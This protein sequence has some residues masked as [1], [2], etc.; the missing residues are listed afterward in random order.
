L[1]LLLKVFVN[2]LQNGIY[3][4][5]EDRTVSVK[6][7]LDIFF[8][9]L[10]KECQDTSEGLPMIPIRED[11][12]QEIYVGE[13]DEEG[14]CRWR[15]IVHGDEEGW[16]RWRPIVHGQKETFINLLKDYGIE[17]N[18]AIVEYFSSYY[19]L[20]FD[21]DYKKYTIAIHSVEPRYGYK[22]LRG[23]IGAYTDKKGKITHIAIG[24][25]EIGYTIV[26]E[27]KTGIV[28]L[29]DDD[30]GRMRK[31]ASSLEE[32]VRGWKPDV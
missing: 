22:N 21:V 8:E 11:I 30:K 13:P 5:E 28:K 20:G 4:N 18:D 7:E 3:E 10:L 16:C 26:V 14:W 23:I 9:N 24:V 15:P 19:F 17:N 29:A 31:I 2:A 1:L 6:A 32:F 12:D 25:E 27:V